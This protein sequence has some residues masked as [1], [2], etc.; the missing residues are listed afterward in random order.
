MPWATP[1]SLDRTAARGYLPGDKA[2][3]LYH[4]PGRY[5]A[6]AGY[7]VPELAP[8]Y[9]GEAGI[10]GVDAVRSRD[11]KRW[12]ADPEPAIVR[13]QRRGGRIIPHEVDAADGHASYLVPVPGTGTFCH[14]LQQLVPGLPPQGA[15]PDAMAGWLM[16]LVER[17]VL[18]GPH[19]VEVKASTKSAPWSSRSEADMG[20]RKYNQGRLDDYSGADMVDPKT[21][22]QAL[23]DYI[24]RTGWKMTQVQRSE[25]VN[26]ACAMADKQIATH[27]PSRPSAKTRAGLRVPLPDSLPRVRARRPSP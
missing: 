27:R 19:P 4:L 21:R 17:G 15:E 8:L 18:E 2:H 22:R 11:G 16:S 25:M 20:R 10:N 3:Y 5:I 13:I 7:C 14:R 24:G 9:A 6:L 23:D 12:V 26:A 1:G